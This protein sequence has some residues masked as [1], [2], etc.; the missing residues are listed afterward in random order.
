[1]CEVSPGAA[2]GG[3]AG[4][5]MS[6]AAP[7]P[8]CPLKRRTRA[9][10]SRRNAGSPERG[11]VHSADAKVL[12]RLNPD[13]VALGASFKCA[14][15]WPSGPHAANGFFEPCWAVADVF[16]DGV[17]PGFVA[18]SRRVSRSKVVQCS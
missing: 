8:S 15:A 14:S 17:H 11:A 16:A 7:C 13:G 3:P 4:F 2:T 6:L 5:T 1:G 10:A 12:G 9:E 18:L